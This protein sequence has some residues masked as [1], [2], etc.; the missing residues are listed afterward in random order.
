VAVNNVINARI[1]TENRVKETAW[2]L[3]DARKAWST[4]RCERDTA[5]DEKANIS[6]VNQL[7]HLS[8]ESE[9]SARDHDRS[10]KPQRVRATKIKV[11]PHTCRSRPRLH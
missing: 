1:L 7:T 2:N 4:P 3:H 9:R 5:R 11:R 6:Q 8:T 10:L